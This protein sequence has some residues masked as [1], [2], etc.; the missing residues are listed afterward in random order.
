VSNTLIEAQELTWAFNNGDFVLNKISIEVCEAE[1]VG[2]IGPNGCGKTT[3]LHLLAGLLLNGVHGRQDGFCGYR[4]PSTRTHLGF[5]FQDY[6]ESLLPWRTIYGNIRAGREM[7]CSAQNRKYSSKDEEMVIK[8]IRQL[9]LDDVQN[10]H[11]FEISG[12]QAQLTCIARALALDSPLLI[13]DEPTSSLHYSVRNLVLDVL[14][15]ERRE[16]KLTI[17][18]T[19]H[20]LEEA[21]LLGDRVV[22]LSQRPSIINSVEFS[23]LNTSRSTKDLG[24]TAHLEMYKKLINRTSDMIGIKEKS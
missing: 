13:L 4:L 3:F 22:T 18:F 8:R 24:A 11:P 5:V 15:S 9:N 7:L 6:R 14:L 12:G 20:S 2:I 16:S 10:Q 23:P 21:S 1:I 19:S 17:L